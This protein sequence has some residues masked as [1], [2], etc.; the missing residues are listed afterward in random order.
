MFVNLADN[1]HLHGLGLAPFAKVVKGLD[2][3]EQL[4]AGSVEWPGPSPTPQPRSARPQRKPNDGCR[5][6][7]EPQQSKILSEASPSYCAAPAYDQHNDRRTGFA[8]T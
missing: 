1:T 4:F 5:Y 7:D 6:G 3:F 8:N 2:V